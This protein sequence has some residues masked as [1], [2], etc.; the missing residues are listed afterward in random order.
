MTSSIITANRS[1]FY[2]GRQS[3]EY[4]YMG[5]MITAAVIK[6]MNL[7]TAHIGDSSLFVVR[8]DGVNKITQDHTLAEKMLQE[9]LLEDNEAN[10]NQ[11]RHILTRALGVEETVEIDCFMTDLH[12]G[13]N[14]FMATDG[15]TDL[16]R[17]ME[18][19][20]AVMGEND[21]DQALEGLLFLALDRGGHDNITMILIALP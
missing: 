20:E 1:I 9:G 15:V 10:V 5:T 2:Q 14:L 12:P 4:S 17:P 21:L 13:D 8:S 3:E 19:W 18:V 7:Y 16:I 11:Y 6:D